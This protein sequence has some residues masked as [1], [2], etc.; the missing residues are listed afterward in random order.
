M[1]TVGG[2]KMENEKLFL[3]LNWRKFIHM[4]TLYEVE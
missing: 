3:S 4:F 2:A 1:D